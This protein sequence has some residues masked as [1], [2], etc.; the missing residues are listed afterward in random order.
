MKEIN[1]TVTTKQY[2]GTTTIIN[3]LHVA[4]WEDSIFAA[5]YVKIII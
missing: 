2:L 4:E 1:S 5:N 3:I